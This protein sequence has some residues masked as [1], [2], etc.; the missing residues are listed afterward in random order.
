MNGQ[1]REK[2]RVGSIVE[3]VEKKN[4][5]TG[6]LTKGEVVRILTQKK[7]HSHGIKEYCGITLASGGL[8]FWSFFFNAFTI[9]PL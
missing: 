6:K 8:I 5:L 3:I 2:I 1:Y 9:L 4:Q 7:Y